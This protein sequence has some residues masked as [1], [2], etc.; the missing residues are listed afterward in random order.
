MSFTLFKS[1]ILLTIKFNDGFNFYKPYLIES[2][3]LILMD[4]SLYKTS[5]IDKIYI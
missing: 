1:G 5:E 2:H 3:E 4:I